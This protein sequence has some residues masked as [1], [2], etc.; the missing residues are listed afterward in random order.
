MN[1]KSSAKILK[2]FS[3]TESIQRK[4][5]QFS[6]KQED[7]TLNNIFYCSTAG[8]AETFDK[9]SKFEEHMLSGKHSIP[10]EISSLD[11]VKKVLY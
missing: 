8:W 2:C 9:T 7:R 3:N 10:E 6:K 5:E 1:I 11:Q 4:K